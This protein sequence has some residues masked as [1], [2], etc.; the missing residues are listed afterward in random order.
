VL[1]ASTIDAQFESLDD[2]AQDAEVEE[3]LAKLKAG[4]P[5]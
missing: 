4:G 1:T 5:V 3:R 2:I